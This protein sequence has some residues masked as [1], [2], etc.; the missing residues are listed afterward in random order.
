MDGPGGEDRGDRQA[1]GVEATVGDDEDVRAPLGGLD[2]FPCE[3]FERAGEPFTPFGGEPSAIE[4]SHAPAAVDERR[5]QAVEIR[6]D[7]TCESERGS[8]ARR[9]AEQRRPPT[10]L[11]AQVHHDPL[12]LRVD[13]WIGDLGK[14][15][16]R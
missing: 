10:D 12:A 7:R 1:L 15:C 16:R 2:R 13:R 3:P 9:P 11:H 5:K 8:G 6:H 14:A 4:P